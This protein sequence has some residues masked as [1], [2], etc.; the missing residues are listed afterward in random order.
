MA[1]DKIDDNENQAEHT[2]RM[3]RDTLHI[4]RDV[5]VA[6]LVIIISESVLTMTINQSVGDR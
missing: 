3:T 6:L 5:C 1:S 4:G 2:E